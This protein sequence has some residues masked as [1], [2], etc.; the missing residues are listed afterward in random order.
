M[1]ESF[2]EQMMHLRGVLESKAKH[3]ELSLEIGRQSPLTS[4]KVGLQKAQIGKSLRRVLS[5]I[6]VS[7]VGN[8]ISITF[9]L[10]DKQSVVYLALG[11]LE[12]RLVY[13]TVGDFL[14]D[15]LA[16]VS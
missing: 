5:P 16:F 15:W 6:R 10:V 9:E 12:R 1:K 7:V 2:G 13:E 11:A 14:C 4:S 8:D 3:N